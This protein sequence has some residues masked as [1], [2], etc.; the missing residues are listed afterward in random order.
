MSTFIIR[1]QGFFYTDEYYAPGEV[2]KQ[3][4]KKTYPTRTA[5]DAACAA[6]VRKWVRS[7]PLG[8]Y[9]FDDAEALD[10]IFEYLR[11]QWPGEFESDTYGLYETEIPK[12]ATDKQVDEIVKRMGV[13]FAQ[14]FEV[15]EAEAEG[16]LDDGGDDD[17]DDD[18]EDED[19]EDEDFDDELHYGPRI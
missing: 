19:F 4:V 8:N 9:V 6:L 1:S 7:E 17:D 11:A 10:K 12:D 16:D 15:S 13:T 5:A 14:V 18:L 2:F 3:V